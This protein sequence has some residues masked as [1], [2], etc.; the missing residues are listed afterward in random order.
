MFSGHKKHG[1]YST[2]F[3]HLIWERG[4]PG[5]STSSSVQTPSISI[6]IKFQCLPKAFIFI[7]IETDLESHVIISFL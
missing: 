6:D 5:C 7:K 2:V 3:R 4:V 1:D